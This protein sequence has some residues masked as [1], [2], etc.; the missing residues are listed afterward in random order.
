MP[1]QCSV[2]RSA[3]SWSESSERQH[4]V[5]EKRLTR[6][7]DGVAAQLRRPL[8]DRNRPVFT[9]SAFLVSMAAATSRG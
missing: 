2:S 5:V 1:G 3:V 7:P 9:A 8:V 4:P 6:T